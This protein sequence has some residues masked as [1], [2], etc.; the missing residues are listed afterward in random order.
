MQKIFQKG[1]KDQ[2]CVLK[3]CQIPSI[4]ENEYL[5]NLI[6][7]GNIWWSESL[8]YVGSR[9][10]VVMASENG[11]KSRPLARGWVLMCQ[12]GACTS[13]CEPLCVFSGESI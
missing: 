11:Q 10:H 3:A 9:E 4:N 8:I 2:A 5:L 6:S 7:S 12:E 13:K 1:E